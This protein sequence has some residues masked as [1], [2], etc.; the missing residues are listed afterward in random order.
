MICGQCLL[1]YATLPNRP[2][3][4]PDVERSTALACSVPA[5][6]VLAGRWLLRAAIARCAFA[7]ARV[8]ARR[9][10]HSHGDRQPDSLVHARI[11][12]PRELGQREVPQ[13]K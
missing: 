3:G 5:D 10:A 13:S 7:A 6:A 2:A 1:G 8:A 12:W 9:A 11:Q 4:A